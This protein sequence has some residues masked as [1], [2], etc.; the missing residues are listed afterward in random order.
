M[1]LDFTA[2][3]AAVTQTSTVEQSAVTLITQIAQEIAVNAGDQQKVSDLA[4]QLNQ[5]ASTLAAA[6]TANTPAASTLATPT[7]VSGSA[8]D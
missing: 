6:I 5:Q 7:P 8:A 2:L 3:T 4:D 1:A